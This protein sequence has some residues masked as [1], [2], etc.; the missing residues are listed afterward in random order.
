MF[1]G[2][3]F[4]TSFAQRRLWFIQAMSPQS[5]AYNLVFTIGLESVDLGALQ[6][7]LNALV[8]RHEILRTFFVFQDGEPWQAIPDDAE[9]PLE[10]HDLRNWPGDSADEFARRISAATA[11]PFV[12]SELP[13][14][15]ALLG[16]FGNGRC[17]LALVIHHIVA[18]AHSIRIITRELETFYRAS[19]SG[20]VGVLPEL[21]IQ[22]ADY[23]VWQRKL[24]SGERLQKLTSYWVERLRELP[25]LELFH[26]GPRPASGVLPGAMR[27]FSIPAP[28]VR[29]LDSLS[30]TLGNTLFASLLTGFLALLGRFSEQKSFAIGTP[31]SGRPK[32]ELEA[33]VGL[34]VNSLVF[35]ADLSGDPSFAELIKR[36]SLALAEDLTHQEL[37]FELLVDA[38]DLKRRADRNPLFQV[39]FQLQPA[40]SQTAKPAGNGLAS[41]TL[42]SQFDLSFIQ[43]ETAAGN[44][45]GAAVYAKDLFAADAIEQLIESY[46]L[47]LEAASQNP[48][49][50]IS[51]LPV[52][53]QQRR[54]KILSLSQGAQLALPAECRLHDLF[55]LQ[56]KS[57]PNKVALIC[58]EVELTFAEISLQSNGIAALLQKSGLSP[59]RVAAICLPRSE[60]LIIAIIAVLKAGGAYVCLDQNAPSERLRSLVDDCD[61]AIVLTDDH[62]TNIAGSRPFL[63]VQ[64]ITLE[65][66]EAPI[67][68]A[69]G[70]DPAYVIYTSGST[71]QP[72]GV[73]ISHRAVV[74]HMLWM[75]NEF[76]LRAGDRVLQR[77]PLTFDAS[78]WEV[79]IPLL[80]GATLVLQR[81]EKIFDPARL[82]AVIKKFGIT[83][84]QVVP[85]LL[86]ALVQHGGLT[87]CT[88]LRRV[89]CGGEALTAELRDAF[90]RQSNAAL[91]NLYGPSETTIQTTFQVCER[92]DRRSFVPIGKPISNV[93]ARVLDSHLELLPVRVPGELYIGGEAVGLGY[94]NN[95][96]ITAERFIDDPFNPGARLYRTGDRARLLPSGEIQFLG[97]IDDQVKLRGYRIEPGEIENVLRQHQA[98][99]ETAVVIQQYGSD[100]Q[101]LTA[102]V[103]PARNHNPDLPYELLDWLGKRL[104]SYLV[105]SSVEISPSLPRTPHGK[106]DRQLLSQRRAVNTQ[107][108]PLRAEPRNSL[109]RD[110]CACFAELL[111]IGDVGIDD[112]FFRLG[113][114]SLLAISLRDK[115]TRKLGYEVN[116]V[117]I[118]E[119]A[120]PRRLARELSPVAEQKERALTFSAEA[121]I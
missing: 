75:L 115:L 20:R 48:E 72:K 55:E 67:D 107:M 117:E 3:I 31:V 78:I 84:L 40:Q 116:V 63:Q 32:H 23:A 114:H 94:L 99:R 64:E 9:L 121:E 86:S 118:F 91:C 62:R 65:N 95:P 10:V 100:D 73:V 56:A 24:L 87:E 97:R 52:L 69:K 8:A 41:E 22:Y 25:D 15:R 54:A 83:T 76:P 47:M 108:R 5:T 109:E 53:D 2:N 50:P 113:G 16:T 96:E 44:I 102:F 27:Q 80:S 93:V 37:P 17:Q 90:F 101:R 61:A 74:N 112:D 119:F 33:I 51:R 111:G 85:S 7:A 71:G 57:T 81:E 39:M 19:V 82:I 29:R 105:P 45:E 36:T 58:D 49:T 35:R 68:V 38:L 89:F 4:P 103:V 6:N 12:L 14:V 43:Y 59:G 104:P 66:N 46:V 42:T 60:R 120:T 70:N 11:N 88:S 106:V 30:R 21:E 1:E 79:F 92:T 26:D 28:V 34:F 77:T 98:V 18:D 13:L 110:I